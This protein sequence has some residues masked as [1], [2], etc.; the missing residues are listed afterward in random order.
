MG[1][2]PCVPKLGLLL[3]HDG[4]CLSGLICTAASIRWLSNPLTRPQAVRLPGRGR[5]EDTRC[6]VSRR[7][8]PGLR[9]AEGRGPSVLKANPVRAQDQ[10]VLREARASLHLPGRP[11]R[12]SALRPRAAEPPGGPQQTGWGLA[13]RVRLAHHKPHSTWLTSA[14]LAHACPSRLQTCLLT[15]PGKEH[16]PQLCCNIWEAGVRDRHRLCYAALCG[17]WGGRWPPPHRTG[18]TCWQ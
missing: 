3:N 11:R 12:A 4:V 18:L 8:H 15:I 13:V 10:R 5:C 17:S 9:T 16:G 6:S 1:P 14:S 2:C 7:S